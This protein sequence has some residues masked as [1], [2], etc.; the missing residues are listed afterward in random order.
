MDGYAKVLSPGELREMTDRN[1][2]TRLLDVRT[3]VEY[4]AV[5]IA[6]AYNVPLDSLG[7]HATEIRAGVD[8]PV[9]LICQSGM[10][11]RR[12]EEALKAAGMPNLHVLDGGV[13]GWVAAGEEV[14]RGRKRMTIERQVRTLAG[15]MVAAAG[16][17][18]VLVNPG[19]A[20]LAVGIGAG[21][22][23][24][25]LTDRCGMAL[26]LARLPF[27]RVPTC[28]VGAMV[29]ALKAGDGPGAAVSGSVRPPARA[30]A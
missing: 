4:E 2:R 26:L 17:L 10:R 9:V 23:F 18:A 13:N 6:G 8:E 29:D 5:H 30:C 15:S 1:P 21:L 19:F 14:I 7:E 24:A 27:N 11:A 28:D 12:A 3:P 25:G 20:L 22:T 16:M